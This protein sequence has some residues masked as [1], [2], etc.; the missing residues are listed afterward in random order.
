[1]EDRRNEAHDRGEKIREDGKTDRLESCTSG[2]TTKRS[3]EKS[4]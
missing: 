1:M 3:E 4:Q 2:K